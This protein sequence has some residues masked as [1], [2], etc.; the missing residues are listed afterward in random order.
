LVF[1]TVYSSLTWEFHC[2]LSPDHCRVELHSAAD[3]S[4]INTITISATLAKDT[5]HFNIGQSAL[6]LRLI[7]NEDL[8]PFDSASQSND[9]MET[10]RLHEAMF[11]SRQDLELKRLAGY[12]R[13]TDPF[14]CLRETIADLWKNVYRRP[15]VNKMVVS[16]SCLS[17][18]DF[19]C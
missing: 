3:D 7:E 1:R 4:H 5:E 14:F 11:S 16:S 15:G 18:C 13:V 10:T 8:V 6:P 9:Y 12:T 17:T 2:V 19:V